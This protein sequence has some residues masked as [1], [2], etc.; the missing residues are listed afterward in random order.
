MI[1]EIT[2]DELAEIVH[3]LWLYSEDLD[4]DK[5]LKKLEEILGGID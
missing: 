5:L 4:E 1:I 2:E 3:R